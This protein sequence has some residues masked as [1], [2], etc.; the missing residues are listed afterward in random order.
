MST[1]SLTI[2]G[3]KPQLQQ[4]SKSIQPLVSNAEKLKWRMRANFFVNFVPFCGFKVIGPRRGAF[5][6]KFRMKISFF[7]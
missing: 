7:A 3:C 4:E 5:G 1:E 2:G 6:D